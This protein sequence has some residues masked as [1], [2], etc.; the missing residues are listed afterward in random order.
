M[1]LQAVCKGGNKENRPRMARA[2]GEKRAKRTSKPS[3]A[4]GMIDLV[5]SMQLLFHCCSAL[6]AQQA[7]LQVQSYHCVVLHQDF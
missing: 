7:W 3:A 4:D 5:V 1:L 2:K 6:C